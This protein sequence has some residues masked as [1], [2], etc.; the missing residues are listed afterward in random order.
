M[1]LLEGQIN[2]KGSF[3]YV[4]QQAWIQ[5]MSL[6]DNILFNH[7]NGTNTQSTSNS[8]SKLH[9]YSQKRYDQVLE[10]CSLQSDLEML[11][12]GDETEIGENG[13]NLSGVFH[14]GYF[15]NDCIYFS[16]ELLF[17]ENPKV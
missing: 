13:I 9:L 15:N 4:S 2:L 7:S 8:K 16:T 5:N 1:E 17:F 12:N 11:S 10:A 3:A 6:K 14:P